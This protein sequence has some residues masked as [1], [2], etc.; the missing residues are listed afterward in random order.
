MATDGY[1][2]SRSTALPLHTQL[3]AAGL[4]VDADIGSAAL[5]HASMAVTT[6]APIAQKST[7][8]TT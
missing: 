6:C 5:V 3:G 2:T 1:T 4:E 7:G 8:Q